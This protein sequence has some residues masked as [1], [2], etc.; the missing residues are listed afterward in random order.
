MLVVDSETSQDVNV[1][2]AQMLKASGNEAFMKKDH[3][4]AVK[5]YTE[6]LAVGGETT[7]AILSNWALCALK[8][9]A[10][11]DVVAACTAALRIG[12]GEKALHR[13]VTALSRLGE[14]NLARDIRRSVQAKAYES[15]RDLEKEVVRANMCT[16][17]FRK[18]QSDD[19][20]QLLWF[21]HDTP[22]VVNRQLARAR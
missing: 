21:L 13:L 3:L 18:G 6:A 5:L 16:G 11:D 1:G 14:H 22:G 2:K 8:T 10:L 9:G 20:K 4:T 19:L 17:W 12:G 7:R 15:L